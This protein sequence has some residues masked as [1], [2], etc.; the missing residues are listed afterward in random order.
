[1]T[2]YHESIMLQK[3]SLIS[4]IET[5]LL[6]QIESSVFTNQSASFAWLRHPVLQ[7]LMV[8]AAEF[9]SQVEVA[10]Q[11]AD[12]VFLPAAVEVSMLPA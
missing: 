10:L 4:T 6:S 9:A 3:L 2:A 11:Q 8:A 7:R 5:K 12:T 1:M